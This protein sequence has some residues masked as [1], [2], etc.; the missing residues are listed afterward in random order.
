[1]SQV[2]SFADTAVLIVMI[3]AAAARTIL[4]T[5]EEAISVLITS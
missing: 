3:R 2:S 1:M 4:T 5:T